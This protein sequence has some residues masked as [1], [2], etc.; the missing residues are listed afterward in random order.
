LKIFGTQE[1]T[2]GLLQV[3]MH[4]NLERVGMGMRIT[5]RI[6]N[7]SVMEAAMNVRRS[8]LLVPKESGLLLLPKR[9]RGRNRRLPE[10]FGCK[11]NC[12][13]L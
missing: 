6:K 5:R 11:I 12:P 8:D 9:T 2:I 10:D 7:M 1:M 13:N 4:L 3:V